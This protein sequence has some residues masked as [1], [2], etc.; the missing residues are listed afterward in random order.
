MFY[1][2]ASR[3]TG[4]PLCRMTE[5]EVRLLR[6][7]RDGPLRAI[8]SLVAALAAFIA[9]DGA[10]IAAEPVDLLLVLASDVSRSID[11]A[12]FRLQRDGYYCGHKRSAPGRG[13]SLWSARKHCHL[14]CGMVGE[15]GAKGCSTTGR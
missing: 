15:R 6:R 4:E 11:A 9:F 3:Y 12:K 10:A 7:I 14:L 5:F 1:C 2:S 8:C 13:H